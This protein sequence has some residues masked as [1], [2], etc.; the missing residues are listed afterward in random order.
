[1]GLAPRGTIFWPLQNNS[2]WFLHPRAFPP[3]RPVR[4]NGRGGGGGGGSWAHRHSREAFLGGNADR[5][6]GARP[7]QSAPPRRSVVD[8]RWTEARS[9]F[10]PGWSWIL[11]L[12][13]DRSPRRRPPNLRKTSRRLFQLRPQTGQTPGT[14][15]PPTRSCHV[16]SSFPG[17]CKSA[18]G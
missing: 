15:V 10:C 1:M 9:C 6:V 13:A 7:S 5:L 14:V 11:I 2:A 3:Q 17:A 18:P 4:F 8:P 12:Q 16:S